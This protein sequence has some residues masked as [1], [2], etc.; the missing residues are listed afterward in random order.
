MDTLVGPGGAEGALARTVRLLPKERYRCSLATFHLRRGLSLLKGVPCPVYEFPIKRVFSLGTLRTAMRLREFIQS[1]QVDII[2]TFFRTADLL[3]GLVAK[4]SGCPLMISS[5]RDMGILLTARHRFAYRLVNP[6]FD[7]VQAVSSAVREYTI[8]GGGLDPDKVVT[9]PNGIEIDKI[10]MQDGSPAIREAL[11]LEG[12]PVVLTVGN[13]RRVKGFDVLV[14]A[15]ARV[16]ARRPAVVFLIAGSV[17][18]P[19][20][21]R[22]LRTLIGQ[23]GLENNV[24]FLGKSEDVPSLLKLCDVFCLPSRSEGMPNALLEA[25][26][27]RLP[28]VATAVGG[29]PEVIE[30][31]RSG[32]L[33]ASEDDAAVAERILSLLDDPALAR[34]IGNAARLRVEQRFSAQR[35]VD[36]MVRMYDC[37]L[38]ARRKTP[39]E[40]SASAAPASGVAASRR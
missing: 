7:Q 12:A 20:Y 3:G 27:C 24:R 11:G 32:Y 1:E 15:A 33:V 2:H 6:L 8:R 18:E 5:R 25:M 26:A 29:T 22:E 34:E 16:V 14:R 38:E 37:L 30:D 13:I 35:M 23:L 17:L 39:D 31:G 10:A 36:D 9:I 4:L 19:E 28:S 40:N 21:E